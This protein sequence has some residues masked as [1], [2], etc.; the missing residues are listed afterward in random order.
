MLRVAYRLADDAEARAAGAVALAAWRLL[1]CRDGGR[2]DLRSD[3]EGRPMFLEV[4]PLAGLHPQDSD[5]VFIARFAGH[6]HGWLIDAIMRECLRA[7]RPPLVRRCTILH[8]LV[9]A[10]AGADEQ[11]VLA[12]TSAVRGAL[13]E[14]GWAVRTLPVSLDLGAAAASLMA[15]PADLV[16]NLVES[17]PGLPG[18]DPL[19]AA[20]AALLAALGV[21]HTGSGLAAIALTADKAATRRALRNAGIPVP[22]TPEQG[23]SGPWIVKHAMEHASFGL[24]ARAVVTTLPEPLPRGFIAERFLPGREFNIALLAEGGACRVLPIAEMRYA[25]DWPDDVP[26]ILDY[27]AKWDT[28]HPRY[29]ASVPRFD[30]IAA[31]L[32]DQLAHLA[33]RCWE[34]LGLAGY[35]RIDVRLDEAGLPAIIDVN[36]NPCLSPDAGF[37]AAAARAGIAYRDLVAGIAEAP[38]ATPPRACPQQHPHGRAAARRFTLREA[39]HDADPAAI[40][41]LCSSTGFFTAAETA[42]AVEL[43]ED[44]RARGG[45]SDYR[46]LLAEQDGALI[47]YACFGRVPMTEWSWDL[48]WI[49]VHPEAQRSGAGRALLESLSATARAEGGTLL[50][51]ETAGRALYA[52]TR[53]FYAGTGFILQAVLPDFYAPGDDKQIWVRR[54]V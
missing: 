28:A 2:V 11:D 1:G 51:A 14:A 31:D 18:R 26:R 12:A 17:L 40:A 52:P 35:A 53:R 15:E 34:A 21:P 24:D 7:S 33:R 19:A 29:A 37:A 30:T 16:F 4:N 23:G 13:A 36:A 42:I 41:A 32:A 46:F 5:L 38:L 22:C 50:Y 10:D 25:E 20:A 27:A 3:A 43:A 8:Q 48:Y 49:V 54:L 6:D 39:L 44:R 45:A 47:A 9:A